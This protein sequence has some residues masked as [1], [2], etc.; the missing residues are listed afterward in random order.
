MKVLI[1]LN[2]VFDTNNDFVITYDNG[3]YMSY[4]KGILTFEKQKNC[5]VVKSNGGY[6]INNIKGFKRVYHQ[7]PNIKY[8]IKI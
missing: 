4:Y 1:M 5:K 8:F 2:D 6:I 7:L 3:G